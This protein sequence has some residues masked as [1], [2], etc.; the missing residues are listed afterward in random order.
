MARWKVTAKH[1]IHATQYGQPTEWERQEI[2]GD[3]G[4]MFRKAYKVPML[5]DPEDPYCINKHEG[6]C[7]VAREGS[8]RPGDIIFEGPPTADMEPMDDAAQAETDAEKHK[9]VNPIDGLPSELGQELGKQI[10]DALSRQMDSA[11]NTKAA[12]LKGA[13]SSDVDALRAM[14]EKQQEMINKLLAGAEVKAEQVVDKEPPL[15][16]IDTS[17]LHK[18]PPIQVNHPH[19]ATARRL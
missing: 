4:R 7:V 11:G 6:I 14:V 1:Y 18:P 19:T 17:T 8:E 15:V 3:T 13:T 10:L 5:I 2:N 9:W 12:S 16:D